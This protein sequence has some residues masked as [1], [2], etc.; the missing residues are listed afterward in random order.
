MKNAA[1]AL[2]LFTASCGLSS[3][4]WAETTP[5]AP[6]LSTSGQGKV[7]AQ[8]DMATLVIDVS[9]TQAQAS[10]AKKQTDARVARY[11][12]FLHQQGIVEA[13]PCR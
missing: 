12:D 10:Q 2:G 8:P 6:H 5:T 7:Q 1:L 13:D 3:L 11:F 9:T 4:A